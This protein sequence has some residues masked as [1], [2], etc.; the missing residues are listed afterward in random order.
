ME[1]L[2][3]AD[4]NPTCQYQIESSVFFVCVCGWIFLLLSVINWWKCFALLD[5]QAN[6]VS[7]ASILTQQLWY[8]IWKGALTKAFFKQPITMK[9]INSTEFQSICKKIARYLPVHMA[10]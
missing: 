2:F 8:V 5:P 4:E 6:V 9:D 7:F 10:F 3:S 1:A